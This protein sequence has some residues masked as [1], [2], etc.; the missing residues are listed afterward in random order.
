MQYFSQSAFREAEERRPAAAEQPA[1]PPAADSFKNNV[2]RRPG[3]LQRLSRS[4]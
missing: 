1:G 2:C 4:G 3:C